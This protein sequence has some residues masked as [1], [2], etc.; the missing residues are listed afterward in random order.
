MTRI[1]NK[2]DQL[3]NKN[4]DLKIKLADRSFFFHFISSI[5]D[6]SDHQRH[7]TTPLGPYI[8]TTLLGPYI[9]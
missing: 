4:D 6:K 3:P 1:K 8:A 9:V 2:K 7:A 5:S